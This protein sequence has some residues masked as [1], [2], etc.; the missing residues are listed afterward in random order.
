MQHDRSVLMPA[1]VA[2]PILL[3]DM[4]RS[5]FPSPPPRFV[6]SGLIPQHQQRSLALGGGPRLPITRYAEDLGATV[7]SSVDAGTTHVVAQRA[8]TEKCQTGA[9][10]PGCCVVSAQWLM[11]CYWSQKPASVLPYLFAPVMPKGERRANGNAAD[12]GGGRGG[13]PG[14]RKRGDDGE[15]NIGGSGADKHC[16]EEEEEEEDDDDNDDDDDEDDDEDFA[17]SLLDAMS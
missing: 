1:L 17:D 5:V 11:Q 4:R 8:G 15:T 6:F 13:L 16:Q 12:G 3:R 2:V 14:K 7:R 9:K 10:V